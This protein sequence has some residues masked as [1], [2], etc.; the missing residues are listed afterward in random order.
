MNIKKL[1]TLAGLSTLLVMSGAAQ[2]GW[3]GNFLLGVEG[4]YANRDGDLNIDVTEAAPATGR[5]DLVLDYN[6]D[7]F[8]WGV[9]AGYQAKCNRVLLGLE[10]N[11]S[12]Q[13]FGERQTYTG[14]DGNGDFYNIAAEHER[15]TVVGLTFRAGYQLNDWVMPYLRAGAET[16]EDKIIFQANNVTQNSVVALEDEHRTYRFVGGAGLEFP[17]IHQAVLRLEYKYSSSGKASALGNIP[18]SGETI[19]T[20]IDGNNQHAG[21]VAFVWNFR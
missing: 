19:D 8:I 17:L 7:G 1:S 5:A 13:D 21:L 20:E 14:F 4:G 18:G 12:W 3:K 2:A 11:V 15:G 6:E 9:L 10:A 16:S